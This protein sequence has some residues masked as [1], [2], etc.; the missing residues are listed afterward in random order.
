MR[1]PLSCWSGQCVSVPI[2]LSLYLKENQAPQ[3]NVPSHSRS[4]LAREIIDFVAAQLPARP[5]RV[6]SDGG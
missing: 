6:L 4:A 5:I 2:G 3:L 1:V